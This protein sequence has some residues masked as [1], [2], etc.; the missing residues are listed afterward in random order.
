MNN[1]LPLL[2][3]LLMSALFLK[4]AYGK[5]ENPTELVSKLIEKAMPLPEVLPGIVIAM[6]LVFP[7]MI[8]VGYKTR[9]AAFGL[10]LWLLPVTVVMH[11]PNDD[12]QLGSFMKNLAIIGGLLF[13]AKSGASEWAVEKVKYD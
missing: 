9:L 5:I 6:E 4:S 13:M 1:L 10:V 8:L 11:P 7:V 3:R 12:K 2:G